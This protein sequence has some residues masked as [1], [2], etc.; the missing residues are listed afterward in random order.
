MQRPKTIQV[1][2]GGKIEESPKEAVAPETISE[3]DKKLLETEETKVAEKK[4]DAEPKPQPAKP[5][6]AIQQQ[7]SETSSRSNKDSV[8]SRTL[9][10]VSAKL[11]QLELNARYYIKGRPN[12]IWGYEMVS[13]YLPKGTRIRKMLTDNWIPIENIEIPIPQISYSSY[14]YIKG[15]KGTYKYREIQRMGLPGNTL[16]RKMLTD[17]WFPLGNRKLF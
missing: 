12:S 17:L 9:P 2:R 1:V 6:V 4:V 10:Q 11:E 16:I 8:R 13:S 5:R 7:K 3:P 14:Y 15:K